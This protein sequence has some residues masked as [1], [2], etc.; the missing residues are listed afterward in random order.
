MN[1]EYLQDK[2]SYPV[3]SNLFTGNEK[4]VKMLIDKGANVNAANEN[5]NSALIF[6][7]LRG[8]TSNAYI[9][10]LFPFFVLSNKYSK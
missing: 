9:L 1:K 4:M 6:A 5:K 8:N 3:S 7:A 10:L 2:N